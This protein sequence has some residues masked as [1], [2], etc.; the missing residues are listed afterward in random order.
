MYALNPPFFNSYSSMS[1]IDVA[2]VTSMDELTG[3]QIQTEEI[4]IDKDMLQQL[5]QFNLLD[6]PVQFQNHFIKV[7]HG[8]RK[9]Y[10]EIVGWEKKNLEVFYYFERTSQTAAVKTWV[11]KNSEFNGKY[12]KLPSHTNSEELHGKVQSLLKN[13]PNISIK[14]N[15]S[16][17]IISKIEF[18]IE[19][20]ERF[21][22]TKCFFDD[23]SGLIEKS[24]IF[25]D[26]LEHLQ[27]KERYTFRR[28]TE[29]AVIDF[30]YKINR[31]FGR[32]VPIQ[33]KTN[34]FALVSDIQNALL[35]FKQEEYAH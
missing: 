15:T 27:Y 9:H 13:L 20:E 14:R 18:D 25:I 29:L 19:T 28:K 31:F 35:T 30:E 4:S 24:G 32:V 16:D 1:F 2:S 33:N 7:R 11:N 12:L 22:F 26:D 6:L 23:I 34:S 5:K 17:T 10:I 21:P 8:V 3:K